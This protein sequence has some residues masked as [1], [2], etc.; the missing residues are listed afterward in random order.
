LASGQHLQRAGETFGKLDEELV[1]LREDNDNIGAQVAELMKVRSEYVAQEGLLIGQVRKAGDVSA[2]GSGIIDALKKMEE[3]DCQLAGLRS[4]QLQNTRDISDLK[5]GKVRIE[6]SEEIMSPIRQVEEAIAAD[7][8]LLEAGPLSEALSELVK[9]RQGDFDRNSHAVLAT[10]KSLTN[11]LATLKTQELSVRARRGRINAETEAIRGRMVS[12]FYTAQRK[13]AKLTRLRDSQATDAKQIN[14]LER[15]LAKLNRHI[16][17]RELIKAGDQQQMDLK[18]KEL[19]NDMAQMQGLLAELENAR[20]AHAHAATDAMA[21]LREP[22]MR[23]CVSPETGE[24]RERLIESLR[25]EELCAARL[26]ALRGTQAQ[27]VKLLSELQASSAP[28]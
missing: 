27:D 18:A 10:N 23:D 17:V 3:V 21:K 6:T 13:N 7:G 4:Q 19:W 2:H 12:S 5:R 25:E 14:E 28:K 22:G 20:A 15:A 26:A 8:V 11:A 9:S 24:L 16:E 1:R